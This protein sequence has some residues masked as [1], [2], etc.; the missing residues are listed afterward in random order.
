MAIT[1]E[2]RAS[3]ARYSGL[4]GWLATTD[5]KR[6]GI[7]YMVSAFAFFLAGVALALIMRTEL[8]R[9]GLQLL[10]PDAYNQAFTMH[11]VTMVFLW[12]LPMLAGLGNYLAP[13]Q[14]GARDMAFPRLNALSYWLFLAAGVLLYSGF[15]WGRS[16]DAGWT[17][18]PPLSG[19]VYSPQ[20]GADLWILSLLL[21]GI[22]SML[23]A[24][25]FAVTILRLRAPGMGLHRM[26]LFTWAVL[27]NSLVILVATPVLAAALSLLLADRLLGTG[28]FAS[29]GGA[30]VLW[31]H[32]FWFYSHP[33]VYLMILPA[34]GIVS[35]V[36]PVF[37]RK[38]IFGYRAIA[39]STVAI[40]ILG[41][42]VWGHHMFTVGLGLELQA[43]F[44]I[45]TMAVAIPSGV[46][47]FNWLA[48]LWGGA[49]TYRTAMLFALSFLALF[50][51][52]GISGVFQAVIPV[53]WQ[54]HD[55]YWVV[56]HFHYTIVGGSVL[57][58]FAGVYYWFPKMTGRK[59]GEGL[60][61]AHFWLF[62]AGLNLTFFPMFLLGV[63]GMPRR[64]ADYRPDMGWN[65]LN[66]IATIGAF[67][68]AVSLV[69]FLVNVF[70]SLARGQRAGGDP[71][72]GDTL[73]WLTSSPPPPYNFAA[74]PQVRSRRPARER[75]L[76]SQGRAVVS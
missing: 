66:F 74:I 65:D 62:V 6:I 60:G 31:Q 21:I 9:P 68:M 24:I 12:V 67:T 30:P 57:G 45:T 58:I 34:M 27:V 35:E 50:P 48:T 70:R 38:P 37:S 61:Q 49:I 16:A 29:A 8:A 2:A 4:W 19:R 53:D 5:H 47:I 26:P 56:A 20:V 73:E 28:F 71:W 55:T 75:R 36:L 7:L 1:D 11:G 42:M 13:L 76:E 18:Y 51:I 40:G 32:M 10:A 17:G 15:L 52:G 46:K 54:L 69:V 59:L 72:E 22:S 25:N 64:I 63:L 43:A 33:A 44:M 3:A 41:F 39:Y 23:G 14:I